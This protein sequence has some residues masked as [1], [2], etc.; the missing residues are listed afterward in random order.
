[1]MSMKI[2]TIIPQILQHSDDKNKRL[3]F[4]SG[5]SCELEITDKDIIDYGFIPEIVGRLSPKIMYNNLSKEDLKNILLRGKLSPILLK[6][7]F[8]KDIYGVDLKY[9]DGYIDEILERATSN[10]TGA[11]ELK[12]IVYSS[13]LDVSHTLQK[14]SN[15]DK[16]RE[17]IVDKEILS[18]NKVYTLKKR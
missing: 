6:Q 11:R 12:Q 3:G 10:N 18:N 17:I 15:R 13:L 8:Y 14:F 9:T 5:Y 4:S 16:Y 7:Q 2:I 1:M